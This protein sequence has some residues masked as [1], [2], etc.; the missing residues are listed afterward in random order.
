MDLCIET[1]VLPS[2]LFSPAPPPFPHFILR[3]LLR[4]SPKVI[5]LWA[6]S[7][8]GYKNLEKYLPLLIPPL[9]YLR[10]R[11]YAVVMII[12]W[13]LMLF[14]KL[15]WHGYYLWFFGNLVEDLHF[16]SS[17]SIFY[18]YSFL[19]FLEKKSQQRD[20]SPQPLSLSV[21]TQPLGQA[22]LCFF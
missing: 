11:E 5:L 19:E 13:V 17:D 2:I 12:L 9:L 10:A 18:S 7:P 16:Y 14:L 1:N 20:S 4:S 21:S 15:L 22:G 3:V 6:P 8:P